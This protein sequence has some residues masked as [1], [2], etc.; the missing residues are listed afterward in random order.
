MPGDIIAIDTEE[1]TFLSELEPYL[2]EP[3]T[4]FFQ[5]LESGKTG[6]VSWSDREGGLVRQG[7]WAG[8]TGSGRV[9]CRLSTDEVPPSL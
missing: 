4:L 6:S 1:E 5:L 3:Q 9:G 2:V 8:K 7:E